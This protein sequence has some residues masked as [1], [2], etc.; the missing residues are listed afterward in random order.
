MSLSQLP[1]PAELIHEVIRHLRASSDCPACLQTDLSSISSSSR[2][3]NAIA[4]PYLYATPVLVSSHDD[5][6]ESSSSYER[7]LLALQK[8][9]ASAP[10]LGAFVQHLQ[11]SHEEPATETLWKHVVS[12]T[13]HLCTLS[14]IETFFPDADEEDS[15]IDSSPC[16]FSA[17]SSLS[18]LQ[19]AVL[20]DETLAD[21]PLSTLFTSWP[22]LQTLALGSII[23][24][25]SRYS[26]LA[27]LASTKLKHLYFTDFDLDYSRPSERDDALAALP[28]LE[29]LSIDYTFGFTLRSI[30]RFLSQSPRHGATLQTLE[31]R[32]QMRKDNSLSD[33]ADAL[34]AAP[35]MQK[36]D[37]ALSVYSKDESAPH[38]SLEDMGLLQ[39]AELRELS[40]VTIY[41]TPDVA[42][43][44]SGDAFERLLVASLSS[45]PKL[46]KLSVGTAVKTRE[47]APGAQIWVALREEAER[48]GSVLTADPEAIGKDGKRVLL[49]VE[50]EVRMEMAAERMSEIKRGMG[51]GEVVCAVAGPEEE[52]EGKECVEME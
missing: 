2:I 30:S 22:S 10:P 45:L 6:E 25:E 19:T 50:D 24:D 5:D 52:V 16:S 1:L 31:F 29:T 36:L 23:A 47:D 20:H 21:Q 27:A 44:D 4:T 33:L 3:L 46:E 13:P 18:H 12:S 48:E 26:D 37:V 42:A 41:A 39:S 40:Y 15:G 17:L 28:P 32:R 8:T 34:A 11:F 49:V 43:S 38:S 9:V 7:R 51:R 35:N 14:G